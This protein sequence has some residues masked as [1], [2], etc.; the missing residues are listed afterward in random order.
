M[1][2]APTTTP[3]DETVEA[4][5]VDVDGGRLPTREEAPALD[6]LGAIGDSP[7]EHGPDADGNW[8]PR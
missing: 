6:R 2:D 7:V 5:P 1:S 3:S 4:E 8:R